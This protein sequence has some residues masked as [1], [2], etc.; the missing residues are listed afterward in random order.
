MQ[1]VNV[2]TVISKNDND[3]IQKLSKHMISNPTGVED[4]LCPGNPPNVFPFRG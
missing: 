2:I 1:M 3:L 4:F